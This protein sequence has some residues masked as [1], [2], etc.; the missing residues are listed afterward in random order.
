MLHEELP[1]SA[2]EL[3]RVKKQKDKDDL[4]TTKL[5]GDTTTKLPKEISLKLTDAVA[6]WDKK[7]SENTLNQVNVTLGNNKLIAII[8]PVGC[9][10]S[11]LVQSILGELLLD[12]G[13]IEVNGDIS[14]ASQEPWL[15]SASIRQNI[16]FGMPYDKKRYQEVV[17]VCALERDFTLFPNSDKTLVGERGTSLSGGQKARINL[18]RAVYRDTSIYLLDDPL[19]AVDSHVGRHL[20]DECIKKYLRGKAVILITHQLQYLRSA[21]QIV[22]MEHGNVKAIGTY[23]ELSNSG[24]D[25]ANLL[26]NAEEHEETLKKQI[27]RQESKISTASSGGGFPSKRPS[28][29]SITSEEIDMPD[30]S[31][32]EEKRDAGGIS[33]EIY[34]RYFRACGGWGLFVFL[35][36]MFILAQALASGGDYYLTY[37]TNKNEEVD[38]STIF[39]FI[40]NRFKR[41]TSSWNQFWEDF[42][43][44]EYFDIYVFAFIIILTIIVSLGRSFLF[45]SVSNITTIPLK[46]LM[47]DF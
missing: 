15:F 30:Q 41:D 29:L 20:F 14:Y 27:S 25:F 36:F 45:F 37:W 21:D 6:K 35:L 9:G 4:E 40:R 39:S 13:T 18:A 42:Y 33:I 22:I 31:M 1:R 24:L 5:N 12:S 23:T 44:N 17:R 28:I 2:E 11:S 10:K 8:G 26:N 16:L 47:N 19:S 46:N 32:M 38:V 34:K 3:R 43:H 7:N